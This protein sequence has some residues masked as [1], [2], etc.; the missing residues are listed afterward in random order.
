MQEPPSAT[1]GDYQITVEDNVYSQGT[2]TGVIDLKVYNKRSSFSKLFYTSEDI[3]H[4]GFDFIVDDEYMLQ[5]S[6]ENQNFKIRA[7]ETDYYKG[8]QQLRLY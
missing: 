8:M 5:V 6:Q 2:Q 3:L 7:Y 4:N 1:V